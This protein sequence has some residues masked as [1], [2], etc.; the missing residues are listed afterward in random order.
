MNPAALFPNVAA[1]GLVDFLEIAADHDSRAADF[2]EVGDW[3]G[4][5]EARRIAAWARK[6]ARNLE[7]N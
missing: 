6:M 3:S 5:E 2:A 7:R 1:L 4:V